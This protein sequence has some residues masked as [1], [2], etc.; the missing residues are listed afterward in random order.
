MPPGAHQRMARARLRTTLHRL[1]LAE[2]HLS[3]N[4]AVGVRGEVEALVLLRPNVYHGGGGQDGFPQVLIAAD[5]GQKQTSGRWRPLRALVSSPSSPISSGK[6]KSAPPPVRPGRPAS[7]TARQALCARRRLRSTR[8]ESAR[9]PPAF[10]GWR[11]SAASG[12]RRASRSRS[13]RRPRP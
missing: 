9:C 10:C 6:T 2:V 11:R 7:N 13:A 1:R 3:H 8:C 12:F 5:I 4:V